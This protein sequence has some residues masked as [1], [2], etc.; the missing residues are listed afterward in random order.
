ME[1]IRLR[2][3]TTIN[4]DKLVGKSVQIWIEELS[5][6]TSALDTEVSYHCNEYGDGDMFLN[7]YREETDKEMETRIQQE[8]DWR[9][10]NTERRYET[11]LKLKKEFALDPTD[12]PLDIDI[13]GDLG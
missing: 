10:T 3:P 8:I 9:K 12:D 6:Y 5:K 1:K 7:V 13:I 4:L 11:Y 2:I